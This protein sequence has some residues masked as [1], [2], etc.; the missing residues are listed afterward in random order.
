LDYLFSR[1][2]LA[3]SRRGRDQS[4]SASLGSEFYHFFP[5]M[6]GVLL[7]AYAQLFFPCERIFIP[8]VSDF[9]SVTASPPFFEKGLF[10]SQRVGVSGLLPLL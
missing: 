4:S 2:P 8:S 6:S 3:V 1:L 10:Y 7:L 9:F 5:H